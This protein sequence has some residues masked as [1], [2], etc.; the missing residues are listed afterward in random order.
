MLGLLG[1]WL[2]LQGYTNEVQMDTSCLLVKRLQSTEMLVR[3][4][5]R[6]VGAT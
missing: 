2:W 1:A 3:F 6:F 5:A 4:V